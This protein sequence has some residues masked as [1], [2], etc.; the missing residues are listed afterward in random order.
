MAGHHQAEDEGINTC[1]IDPHAQLAMVLDGAP[2]MESY[3]RTMEAARDLEKHGLTGAGHLE[4]H[5]TLRDRLLACGNTQVKQ[6]TALNE[7]QQR[8]SALL[9][10]Y[11]S[12]VSSFL[13]SDS[14]RSFIADLCAS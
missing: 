8:L 9:Q 10:Q 5:Y 12:Y 13:V 4:K 11:K 2:F 6:K 3:L 14:D 1:P 7:A